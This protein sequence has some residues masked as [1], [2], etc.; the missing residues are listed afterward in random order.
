MSNS[1]AAV[2]PE[3]VAEWSEKNLPLTP[4]SITFGSNK[5]VWWKGACGHEW[6][7]SVKARSNGEKCPICSGARVIAGINDLAT[8]EPLLEKQWSKKNKIKP[9]EV[10]IGS[11][12]KVI[13]R[14]EKGH[15]WEA[16]VKSR[17]INKTGCPYCSHNKVLAG[18]N[19]LATLLPDIAAEWSDRNYPL[20]PTQVTVFANRKAWWKCKD[21]G[22]EWNT[23]ISTRSGGSKCPYCSGYIFLKGF[24]DLQTTHP[25]IASEWSEKNLLLKPDEVNAKSRK[26][27]WWRCGK[28][29]NEWK[30]VINARVKGTV[31][32]RWLEPL[33]EGGSLEVVINK[34]A[35]NYF[36]DSPYA[37]GN[38]KS[39]LSLTPF[40]IVG[41]VNDG[42]DFP[43]IYADSAA[44]LNF[45][46]AM[47]QVQ[48][49]NVY[50]HPTTGLT[51]EQIHS[52]LGDILTDTIGGYWE[53]AGR[54]DIGDTYDSVLSILQLGLLVTSLLLLFV[55]VLGQINIGL[56]SLEQRTHELLIRRAIG[57]SRTNIVALVLGSQLILSIFVCFAAILISLILVHCIGALLP[58][59][60]PVGTPS[61]PISVAV[62]A[63][64]VSVLTALLGGLLPALKAAKLEPALALR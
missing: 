18:F 58:V 41:V 56:S 52:A 19:D 62:V 11:H 26:N 55:S 28:C 3:L 17:T 32:G 33:S 21:C 13:W 22:R 42:R 27:V 35:K 36:N 54:S 45:A 44:I 49:A 14:C 23:L 24:N 38:V 40:N 57:A 2:H 12:K 5:K 9:T 25:E 31:S 51:I 10:S 61:Y 34:E 48:N 1:L 50:W 59:D 63:V 64:A 37:A 15:E 39:T 47:W 4:D 43:T 6:Q 30:S 7:T 8:L 20:L 60:S 53:S 16:A 29:G 46:P